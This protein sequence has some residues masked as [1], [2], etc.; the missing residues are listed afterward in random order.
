MPSRPGNSDAWTHVPIS[1]SLSLRSLGQPDSGNLHLVTVTSSKPASRM[2]R[3]KSVRDGDGTANLVAGLEDQARPLR[4]GR[5]RLDGPV[6]AQDGV[7]TVV[8][9]EVAAGLE[10]VVGLL[11]D[12][13]PFGE[14]A[15]HV[16]RKDEVERLGPRPLSF[17]VVH[18]EDTVH[19]TV[20]GLDRAEVDADGFC[21]G[22]LVGVVHTKCLCLSRCQGRAWFLGQRQNLPSQK[23]IHM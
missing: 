12:A 13:L 1:L 21:F 16:A 22:V 7:H 2:R 8:D 19:W 17:S 6:V 9:L 23:S 20:V 4:Y 3:G 10:V 11:H 14:A 18:L 15:N 5:V